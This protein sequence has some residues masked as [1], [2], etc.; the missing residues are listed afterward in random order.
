VESFVIPNDI[1]KSSE[2]P[3]ELMINQTV[4]WHLYQNLQKVLEKVNTGYK[5]EPKEQPQDTIY[6]KVEDNFHYKL[7]SSDLSEKKDSE[8]NQSYGWY[9]VEI[10][11]SV[12]LSPKNSQFP[13]VEVLHFKK[14]KKESDASADNLAKTKSESKSNTSLPSAG[15]QNTETNEIT[16]TIIPKKLS[17]NSCVSSDTPEKR[18]VALQN[19]MQGFLY[20]LKKDKTGNSRYMINSASS[21]NEN[22]NFKSIE[23]SQSKPERA[24]KHVKKVK[25]FDT[26]KSLTK[27]ESA[28]VLAPSSDRSREL[29]QK[30]IS[31][32]KKKLSQA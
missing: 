6:L 13:S 17:F 31:F 5:T 9:S 21:S 10:V 25:V 1:S 8:S 19:Q 23:S 12:R 28:W 15:T 4:K 3:E 26:H 30:R 24:S 18:L 7:E 29:I 2:K 32:L 11:K 14:S 16:Q 20:K 27:S 22:S